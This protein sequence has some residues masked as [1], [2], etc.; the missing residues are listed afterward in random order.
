M[1]HY[2][3]DTQYIASFLS[4]VSYLKLNYVKYFTEKSMQV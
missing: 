2:F 4:D 3:L 1:G